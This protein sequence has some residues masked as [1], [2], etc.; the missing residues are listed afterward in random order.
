V[1]EPAIELE[2]L[3]RDFGRRRAVD[4]LNLRIE[5]GEIVGFLGPNGAGKTTTIRCLLGLAKPT[6]GD[7]R[8]FGK[9]VAREPLAALDGVGSLVE[10]AAIY[11]GVS[12]RDHL[13]AAAFF[14][15]K[16]VPPAE[17][18][19][20]LA[21]VGLADR[22]RDRATEFSRGMKQRLALATAL[23]GNPRLLVLDE[24]TD[25][26]DPIGTVEIRKLLKR[27]RDGG[28][29]VF[30]SSHLLHEVEATCDRVAVLDG[31]KLRA[32]GSVGELKGDRSLEEFFLGVVEAR[33]A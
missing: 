26:L 6:H 19:A 8:I 20:A 16:E 1:G 30:L 4:A 28:A 31:G 10:G 17:I 11:D 23:L 13:R 14:V 25:G 15:G 12:A 22:A 32:V 7:A 27:L 21:A 3:T 24:P 29:T 18:D 33:G 9:S 5:A 2:N